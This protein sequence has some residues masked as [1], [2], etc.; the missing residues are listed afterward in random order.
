MANKHVLYVFH[1]PKTISNVSFCDCFITLIVIINTKWKNTKTVLVV[2]TYYEST[3]TS[4]KITK[5]PF[6]LLEYPSLKRLTYLYCILHLRKKMCVHVCT[7]TWG[8]RLGCTCKIVIWWEATLLLSLGKS[9]YRGNQD[10][11]ASLEA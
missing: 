5:I 9:L 11:T 8:F 4:V 6:Q 7:C 3:C 10:A 2:T 1:S